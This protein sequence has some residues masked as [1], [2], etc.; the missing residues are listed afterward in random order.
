MASAISIC[1]NALT[2]LGDEPINSFDDQSPRARTCSNLWP[3]VRDKFIRAGGWPCARKQVILAPLTDEPAFDWGYAFSLPGDW[4][5]TIQVGQRGERTHFEQIG[6]KLYADTGT[7]YLVYVADLTDVAQWDDA[8]IDAACAEMQARLAYPITQSTTLAQFK[9]QEAT[10][11][12]RQARA[13]AGQDNEPEDWGD[14]PFLD[15]RG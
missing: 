14:S 9:R 1:S 4:K 8:M 7:L 10:L 12:W 13:E 3:Q 5:K 2:Q 11:A 6:R 15:V